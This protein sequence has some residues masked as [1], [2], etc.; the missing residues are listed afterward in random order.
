MY[1]G[2]LDN[3][4][5]RTTGWHEWSEGI[6]AGARQKANSLEKSVFEANS[7]EQIVDHIMSGYDLKTLELLPDSKTQDIVETK[8]DVAGN[9]AYVQAF[10]L[11]QTTRD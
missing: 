3:Y 5:F 6:I 8:I 1:Y 11:F 4:L 9:S 10:D 7:Q 2:R